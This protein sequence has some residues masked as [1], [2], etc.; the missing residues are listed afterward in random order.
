MSTKKNIS[1][2][3]A[4]AGSHKSIESHQDFC[5]TTIGRGFCVL[6]ELDGKKYRITTQNGVLVATVVI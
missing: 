2:T 5:V 1:T 3:K 4:I 6:D